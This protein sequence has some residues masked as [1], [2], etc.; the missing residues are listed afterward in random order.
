MAGLE[1]PV[2]PRKRTVFVIES[3]QKMNNG[4]FHFDASGLWLRPEGHL[5]LCGKEP[6]IENADDDFGIEVDD[7]RF[8][9]EVWPLL[10]HRIPGFE[11]LKLLRA[12]AGLY[13]YNTFDH[14]A[15]IGRH[16]DVAN[17]ILATG[18][19]GHGMMHSPAAGAGVSE[20]VAYGEYRTVDLTP[21]RLERVAANQPIEERVY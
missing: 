5:Y 4:P 14:S 1:I 3:P 20:L 8:E 19:S 17:L 12:W 9:Q 15:I 7:D 11:Q 10:A 21:F 13:E 2:V 16:P 18:F 6:L